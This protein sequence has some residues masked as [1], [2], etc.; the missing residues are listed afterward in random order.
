MGKVK[1]VMGDKTI[2]KDDIEEVIG[3]FKKKL[4]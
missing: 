3:D 2:T 1:N 4:M